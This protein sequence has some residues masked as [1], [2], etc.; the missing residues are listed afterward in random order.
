[1]VVLAWNHGETCY[2]QRI[3]ATLLLAVI[4]AGRTTELIRKIGTYK[5]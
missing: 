3:T 1:M 2:L 4:F 5:V